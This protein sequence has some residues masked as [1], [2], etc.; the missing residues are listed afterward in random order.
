MEYLFLHQ[1]EWMPET[2][3]EKFFHIAQ[4]VSGA[5]EEYVG[6][7]SALNRAEVEISC[8]LDQCLIY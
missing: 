5:Y 6:Q 3:L 7:F 2:N 8:M 4:N 1:Q